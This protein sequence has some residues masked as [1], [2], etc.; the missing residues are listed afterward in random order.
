MVFPQNFILIYL[1]GTAAERLKLKIRQKV[2]SDSANSKKI[3]I[4]AS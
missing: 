2:G 3:R 4:F 1:S